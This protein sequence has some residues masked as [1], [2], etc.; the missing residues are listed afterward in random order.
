MLSKNI[1][2]IAEPYLFLTPAFVILLLFLIFPLFWNVYISLHDVSLVN[3][4]QGW[5]YV[6]WQNFLDLFEDSNFQ[7]SLRVTL[8]FVA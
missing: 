4:L 1:F 2:R 6:G 5:T 8:E 3:L 7:T